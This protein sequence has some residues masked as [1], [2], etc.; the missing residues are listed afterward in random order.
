MCKTC[1]LKT[2]KR[3][4]YLIDQKTQYYKYE[5]VSYPQFIYRFNTNLI[6][7]PQRLFW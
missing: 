7:N 2:T 6:K 4:D 3:S 1:T 5:Y